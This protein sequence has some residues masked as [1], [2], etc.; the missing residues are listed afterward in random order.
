VSDVASVYIVKR[1]SAEPDYDH[2]IDVVSGDC[3][4]TSCVVELVEALRDGVL[5]KEDSTRMRGDDFVFE[6][7]HGV[8]DGGSQNIANI[9]WIQNDFPEAFNALAIE[10]ETF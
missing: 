8:G 2:A 4:A 3:D 1:T 10:W 6:Y 9:E 7:H 5:H